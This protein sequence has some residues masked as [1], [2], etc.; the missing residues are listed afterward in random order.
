[1][2]PRATGDGWGAI[3][4][5]AEGEYAFLMVN[6]RTL[7]KNMDIFLAS[8]DYKRYDIIVFT[9]TWIY[10]EEEG[11]FGIDGYRAF[12]HS[13]NYTAGGVAVF[14]KHSMKSTAIAKTCAECD[15]LLI[16]ITIGKSRVQLAA[17][18]RSPSK[19]VSSID[20]FINLEMPR[21]LK[22]FNRSADCIVLGDFNIDALSDTNSS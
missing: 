10:Q 20:S 15:M 9:E 7:R 16:D 5:R 19:A 14:V 22:A 17:V 18:Y 12:Y 4:G 6:V 8:T 11:G 13:S 3:V 21:L 2:K 1:M